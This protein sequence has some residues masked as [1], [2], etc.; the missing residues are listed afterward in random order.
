VVTLLSQKGTSA[1]LRA[2]KSLADLKMEIIYFDRNCLD[3]LILSS[4]EDDGFSSEMRDTLE[5]L[6]RIQR[7]AQLILGWANSKFIAILR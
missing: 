2:A 3:A 1:V 4:G 6:N 5:L 7:V